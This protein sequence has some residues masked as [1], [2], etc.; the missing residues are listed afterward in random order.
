LGVIVATLL[1]RPNAS[2]ADQRGVLELLEV[3]LVQF[4]V[5]NE[6]SAVTFQYRVSSAILLWKRGHP[7]A[8]LAQL[9]YRT[10]V[11]CCDGK[12][13]AG[14]RTP[15]SNCSFFFMSPFQRS[16]TSICR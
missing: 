11:T 16:G 10:V 6:K 5:M 13:R 7:L 3:L 9:M 2:A 15:C 8:Q 14:A 12:P 1:R 4:Q